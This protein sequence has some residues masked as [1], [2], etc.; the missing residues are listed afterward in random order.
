MLKIRARDEM[1]GM[2]LT[3]STEVLP[4]IEQLVIEEFE[5]TPMAEYEYLASNAQPSTGGTIFLWILGLLLAIGGSY[6]MINVDLF[7]E[8]R[9]RRRW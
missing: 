4:Y 5:R 7:N 6:V 1:P 8:E 9:P 2:K 3:D